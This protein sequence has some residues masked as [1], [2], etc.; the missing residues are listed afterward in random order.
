M[1]LS[2]YTKISVKSFV[3]LW[4]KNLNFQLK[5]NNKIN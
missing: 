1:T 3:V 4:K 5:M 2:A